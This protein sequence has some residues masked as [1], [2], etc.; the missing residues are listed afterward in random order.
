MSDLAAHD[1]RI[2]VKAAGVNRADVAQRAGFYP[3]PP[4]VTDVL[5]LEVAGIVSEIGSDVTEFQKGDRVAAL[6]AGGGY[7]SEVCV[8]EGLVWKLPVEMDFITGAAFPEIFF[9]AFIALFLEG[10]IKPGESLL[11]HA[12]GSGVGTAAMQIAK[13]FGHKVFVTSRSDEKL[14][15]LMDLGAD[16]VLNSENID[17][18]AEVLKETDGKGVDVIID[19]LGGGAL[20]KNIEALANRGRIVVLSTMSGKAGMLDLSKLMRKRGR[21]IGSVLRS[22]SLEEKIEIKK[23]FDQKIFPLIVSGALHPILDCTF[24]LNEADRALDYLKGNRNFGKVVL[25]IS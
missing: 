5:G 25:F 4:G 16:I 8:H 24:P 22:R 15:K 9:T 1:L 21:I 19:M 13:H 11:I 3:P 18:A 12:A 7:A 17:F 23:V 6:L 20:E 10:E 14:E 2:Q